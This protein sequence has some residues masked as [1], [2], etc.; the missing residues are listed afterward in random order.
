[1]AAAAGTRRAHRMAFT[2]GPGEHGGDAA[3]ASGG[4]ASPGVDGPGDATHEA[5]GSW[6]GGEEA[7]S[8]RRGLFPQ[9]TSHHLPVQIV[10]LLL[11]GVEVQ[12]QSVRCQWTRG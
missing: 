12:V 10:E 4:G 1:M 9:R 5:G 6:G 7:R 3:G 11:V 2:G 8:R